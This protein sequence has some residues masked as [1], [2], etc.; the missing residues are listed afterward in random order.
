MPLPRFYDV[1][2]LFDNKELMDFTLS[3][4]G[5]CYFSKLKVVPPKKHN[6]LR[7]ISLSPYCPEP[8][9]KLNPEFLENK[10]NISASFKKWENNLNKIREDFN[11]STLDISS[12][13]ANSLILD[14]SHGTLDSEIN[15][16]KE[17]VDKNDI[18]EKILNIKGLDR[19][20]FDYCFSKTFE[21]APQTAL[22]QLKKFG[23]EAF[24]EE[25][26]WQTLH[27]AS[28]FLDGMIAQS[29]SL[30]TTDFFQFK[31][32][33]ENL[34]A[35]IK[36]I[37]ARIQS[38]RQRMLLENDNGFFKDETGKEFI[39]PYI[40]APEDALTKLL[41]LSPDVDLSNPLIFSGG[42]TFDKNSFS[43]NPLLNKVYHSNIIFFNELDA[44]LQTSA[45]I[46]AAAYIA[47]AFPA[48]EKDIIKKIKKNNQHLPIPYENLMKFANDYLSAGGSYNSIVSF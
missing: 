1:E 20:A 25:E 42:N 18:L 12:L 39:V 27:A 7:L 35:L 23:F 43:Q 10:S 14:F 28:D 30:N 24:R 5:F 44:T 21:F 11:L 13:V 38:D 33:A 19:R 4:K 26:L 36:P 48:I 45:S 47:A 34:S 32:D 22:K 8:L 29:S 40:A 15:K 16:I 3:S 31:K 37:E 2:T 9:K 17:K 41:V 46:F 6:A